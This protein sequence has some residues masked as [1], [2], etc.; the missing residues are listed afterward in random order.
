[1]TWGERERTEG[2]RKSKKLM[3]EDEATERSEMRVIEAKVERERKETEAEQ[4][5]NGAEQR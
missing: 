2:M 3:S 5:N 1:M 4:E